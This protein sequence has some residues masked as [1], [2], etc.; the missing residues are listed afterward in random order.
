MKANAVLEHTHLYLHM[1][2]HMRA[3]ALPHRPRQGPQCHQAF[4]FDTEATSC[5]QPPHKSHLLKVGGMSGHTLLLFSTDLPPL[6]LLKL[7]WNLPP[8]FL[9]ER[10]NLISF[11]QLIELYL[12]LFTKQVSVGKLFRKKVNLGKREEFTFLHNPQTND[13]FYGWLG[14]LLWCVCMSC[15]VVSCA[16]NAVTDKREEPKTGTDFCLTS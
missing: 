13:L 9:M 2:M 8:F 7:S 5:S 6:Q 10:E 1:P 3:H 11:S 16:H 14:P 4:L 15:W 12:K